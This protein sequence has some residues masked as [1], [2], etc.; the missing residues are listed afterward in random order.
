ML[1]MVPCKGTWR[2]HVPVKLLGKLCHLQTNVFPRQGPLLWGCSQTQTHFCTSLRVNK[3]KAVDNAASSFVSNSKCCTWN[4]LYFAYLVFTLT[5]TLP[6]VPGYYVLIILFW[7]LSFPVAPTQIAENSHLFVFCDFVLDNWDCH[8][9]RE[10]I[11]SKN[12]MSQLFMKVVS[13]FLLFPVVF[14]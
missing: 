14:S 1:L 5:N 3:N 6:G 11:S 7:S 4:Q 10:A 9:E 8:I 2:V 12:I 13:P